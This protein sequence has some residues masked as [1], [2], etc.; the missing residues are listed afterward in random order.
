MIKKYLQVRLFSMILV[1]VIFSLPL[2]LMA[3]EEHHKAMAPPTLQSLSPSTVSPGDKLTVTGQHFGDVP[4]WKAV[5]EN[6]AGEKYEMD[7]GNVSATQF[8][9]II[10]DIYYGLNTTERIEAHK[11]KI[12]QQK[13]FYIKKGNS[14]SNKLSLTIRSPYPIIE[15]YSTPQA[16]P[17]ETIEVW[18]SNYDPNLKGYIA[19]FIYLDKKISSVTPVP[20]LPTIYTHPGTFLLKVPDVFAGKSTAEQDA[21]NKHDGHLFLVGPDGKAGNTL[22]FLIRQK[23]QAATGAHPAN[24]YKQ[25]LG[26]TYSPQAPN[27]TIYYKGWSPIILPG[28]Q[29][30]LITN[31]KNSCSSQIQLSYKDKFGKLL[32]GPVGL[33]PNQSTGAFNGQDANAHW[34]ALGPESGSFLGKYYIISIDI[35]WK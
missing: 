4:S 32:A 13:Y 31:V 20:A 16:A 23:G 1:L 14:V 30:A 15:W 35:S 27:R 17:G 25:V 10:P 21:I 12:Q 9:V 34:E 3:V 5:I 26:A 19:D 7:I 24:P 22:V 33:N 18:G 2:Q 29:K 6:Q 11:D 28:S 8:S